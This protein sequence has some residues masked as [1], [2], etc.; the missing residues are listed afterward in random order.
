MAEIGLI[1]FAQV[2][3]QVA[4]AA[5]PRY[6]SR[7]SKYPCAQPTFLA[8]LC[9]M[10]HEDWTFRETEVRLAEHSDLRS[11]LGPARIPDHTTLYRCVRRLKVR[12]CDQLLARTLEKM[13]VSA[14]SKSPPAA[15]PSSTVADDATGLLPGA[16][17]AFFVNRVPDR[18]EG[19]VWLHFGQTGA[20]RGSSPTADSGA[21]GPA[22]PCNS[23]ERR[24][25]YWD[26]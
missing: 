24:R 9:V 6:R 17:S 25:G 1:H 11:A 22:S 14:G 2:V 7:H 19:F 5:L 20:R 15:P 26:A 21:D 13:P 12:H 23:N 3:R 16:M 4:E 18:S 8:L 10:G